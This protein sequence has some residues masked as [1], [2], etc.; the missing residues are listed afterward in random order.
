MNSGTVV[1]VLTTAIVFVI[2]QLNLMT[3]RSSVDMWNNIKV[4]LRVLGAFNAT[5]GT[6]YGGRLKIKRVGPVDF[7]VKHKVAWPCENILGDEKS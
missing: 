4:R 2:S 3:L 7:K 6:N 1:S 5:K